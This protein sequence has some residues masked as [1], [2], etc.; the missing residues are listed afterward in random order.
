MTRVN[1]I[2]PDELH[3]QAKAVCALKGTTL[4]KYIISTISAELR[5]K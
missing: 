4:T 2:V 3:K 1:V 5:K